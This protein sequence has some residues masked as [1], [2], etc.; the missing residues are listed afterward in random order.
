MHSTFHDPLELADERMVVLYE[1]L[2][3]GRSDHPDDAANW[4]VARF[5]DEI[6]TIA[7]AL[8]LGRLSAAAGCLGTEGCAGVAALRPRPVRRLRPSAVPGARG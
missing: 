4:A 8:G 3:S 7:A 1:Q 5:A 2:D 6:D